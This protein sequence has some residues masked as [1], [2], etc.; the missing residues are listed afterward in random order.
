MT[1]QEVGDDVI[2]L[3]LDGSVYLSING[4]GRVLWERLAEPCSQDEL[5]D[6]LVEHFGI[7]ESRARDDV[8]AFL[9]ALRSRDLL[10][11]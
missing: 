5:N 7:D 11:E 9:G 3:D 1:W 4:S 2:V 6:A 8:A 10:V